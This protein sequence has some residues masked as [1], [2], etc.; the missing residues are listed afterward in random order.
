MTRLGLS[1]STP[2]ESNIDAIR[3]NE[4]RN[5]TEFLLE[6][7][8]LSR[9]NCNAPPLGVETNPWK[10]LTK[11]RDRNVEKAYLEHGE[12]WH[13]DKLSVPNRE[14]NKIAKIKCESHLRDW[15]KRSQGHGFAVAP[16]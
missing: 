15:D 8:N 1:A 4:R 7:N 6:I 5:M 11:G 10:P 12:K 2:D 9:R 14:P 3:I 13:G 16:G